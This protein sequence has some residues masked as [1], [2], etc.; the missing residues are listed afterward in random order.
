MVLPLRALRK[1]PPKSRLPLVGR[2]SRLDIVVRLESYRLSQSGDGG[3][4]R[5]DAVGA[6][7]EAGDLLSRMH[8]AAMLRAIS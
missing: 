2:R 3:S 7:A 4:P 1:K 8:R 5:A 6:H